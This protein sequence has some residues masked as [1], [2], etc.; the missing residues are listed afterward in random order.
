MN[1]AHITI[2]ILMAIYNGE[3]YINNQILS[4]FQQTHTNWKLYIRDDCST[5]DTLNIV[6]KYVKQ[7]RRITIVQDNKDNI[8]AGKSFFTLL[9]YSTSNWIIFC[10][11]DDIWFEKK[12]E[13]L[14]EVGKKKLNKSVPSLVYCDANAYS[15]KEGIILYNSIQRLN[16]K[17]LNEFLFLN[18]GYQGSSVLFNKKLA[19]LVKNYKREFFMH[20][21]IISLIAF[22]LGEVIYIPKSLMLYRQHG[23]NVTGNLVLNKFGIIKQFFRTNAFVL[24]KTH[25]NEKKM[26]F[27]EF[28]SLMNETNKKLFKEYLEYPQKSYVCRL[29]IIIKNKFSLGGKIFPLLIKSLLRKPLG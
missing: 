11:Q 6:K 29:F 24:H 8:G 12:L 25:Y 20:D 27:E 22:S 4:L 28:S 18:S 10:D 1:N 2:D 17:K 26:F 23:K 9:E 7:D 3:K 19:S 5:D 13:I 21:D 14:L 16:A 15:D